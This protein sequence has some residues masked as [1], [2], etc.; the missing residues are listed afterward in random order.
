MSRTK[1]IILSASRDIPF[2]RLVLSQTNV[3]R[4]KA[5]M[6]IEELAEDIARRTLLSSIT[7][8]PLL[9]EDGK[10]TGS[11]EIP[12]GGRRYRALE[13]LVKQK[14]LA[15]DAP[16]PCVVRT[17]GLA[18]EDSLAEN[19][20]RAP[21]HPLD[22][23]RAFAAMREKGMSEEDIAAAFFVST[24]V[25]RQR[26][27]LASVSPKLL[28]FYAADEMSLEQLI[29]FT[30]TADHA[31]QEEV[32]DAVRPS[33]QRDPYRIR[34]MLTEGAVR[35]TDRR[36]RLVGLE[37]YEKA[38][39]VILRDLF[40]SDEGGWLQDAA[41][42]DRLVAEKLAKT[43]EEVKAEG[44]KWVETAIEFPHGY[45]F[46]MRR[47]VG[48]VQPMSGDEAARYQ[49][50]KAEYQGI[51]EEHAAAEEVAEDIDR[52]LGELE[53]EIE[54]LEDRPLH[55]PDGVKGI[56]GCLISLDGSG[57]LRIE[58]GFIRREDERYPEPDPA[59]GEQSDSGQSPAAGD[60]DGA[61]G[62]R[63]QG[64]APR[65]S[66]EEDDAVRPLPDRLVTELTA[67]RTV[68]LRDA[69][70]EDHATA[71]LAAL[72]AMVLRTF[73]GYAQE[74][75]L[76][77]DPRSAALASHAPGLAE[78][79][80]ARRIAERHETWRNALPEEADHLWDC[81]VAFDR[82]S[83]DALFAHCIS[84]MVNAV[85]EPWSRRP[86]ALAHADRLALALSLDMV[87]AGWRP[88]IET[89][90]GRVTKGRILEAVREACGEEAAERIASFRKADMAA[91]A[92]E[93]LCE[94]GWLPEPLR[95]PS[96]EE[97]GEAQT[98]DVS[99]GPDEVHPLGEDQ[100][101]EHPLAAE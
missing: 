27:R 73:F 37:Q 26:L 38:G 85:Y 79:G 92:E 76:E 13:L 67:H 3:R 93:L 2:D 28:D 74:S 100:M 46:S 87:G 84:L 45:S 49:M 1:K 51:E 90:L 77:I 16:V 20:Q 42:L 97:S 44:W 66:A 81:L 14:R 24:P 56:A 29:A 99:A 25:V 8:R 82:D 22:Q 98:S 34:R 94:T 36:A 75:C 58:R 31:R 72:H 7:V 53:R 71:F 89:Y 101:T 65:P 69:L 52:K 48:K 11:F 15:K 60:E 18:E 83:R 80:P 86:R 68:A 57:R 88:T 61:S 70:A 43:A 78:T 96:G 40:Q 9:D 62:N 17:A 64:S 39:G 6:S 23:Y 19:V 30:V 12:A 41:L 91:S 59:G 47:S 4:V 63:D 5:G 32:W 50:L 95:T 10:E 55:F 54:A 35:G 33:L 21:L